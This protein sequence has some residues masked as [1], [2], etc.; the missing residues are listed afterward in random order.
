[1][2]FDPLD[3]DYER[4][5]RNRRAILG[6]AWVDKSVANA[7]SFNADFQNMITRFGMNTMVM[8]PIMAQLLS[9]IDPLPSLADA[10]RPDEPNQLRTRRL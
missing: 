7:T 8:S 10:F 1:M 4:G 3:H 5:M 6:D 2:S 9:E